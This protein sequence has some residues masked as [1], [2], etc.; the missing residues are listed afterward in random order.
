MRDLTIL[1]V[2]AAGLGACTTEPS[3]RASDASRILL[4]HLRGCANAMSQDETEWRPGAERAFEDAAIEARR[5]GMND[6]ARVLGFG[7]S[8]DRAAAHR[9]FDLALWKQPAADLV[10]DL[11]PGEAAS[12]LEA[13]LHYLQAGL[14]VDTPWL[15]A[16]GS[17]LHEC[18]A[19][20][21]PLEL[22]NRHPM[23]D[24]VVIA[25]P[26]LF[27]GTLE[28]PKITTRLPQDRGRRERLGALTI[29]WRGP[30]RDRWFETD[31]RPL[32][33]RLLTPSI[34]RKVTAR[35]HL[36]WY[37]T[38]WLASQLGARPNK[39]ALGDDHGPL[40][41]AYADVMATLMQ[42]WLVEEGLQPPELAEET[43]ATFVAMTELRHHEAR[44]GDAPRRHGKA[45][46]IIMRGLYGSAVGRTRAGHLAWNHRRMVRALENFAADLLH[47][48]SA[49]EPDPEDY[50][51]SSSSPRICDDDSSPSHE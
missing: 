50:S 9:G 45:A 25:E 21:L 43:V 23:R 11:G 13:P 32:A 5:R 26:A 31:V 30:A 19:A 49:P 20:L 40:I 47:R 22:R 27:G 17:R 41:I 18:E 48:L 3:L 35:A 16:L 8:R 36:A 6:I 34:A 37:A 29:V 15:T 12:D 7:Q 10:I 44:R 46:R 24:R 38:R 42:L 1:L 4:S 2:A 39:A 28:A 51:T 33:A 14:V